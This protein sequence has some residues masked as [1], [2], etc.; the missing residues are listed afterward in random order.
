MGLIG[1]SVGLIGISVGLIHKHGIWY[2][3]EGLIHKYGI[4]RRV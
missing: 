1:L 2:K 3:E 4:E